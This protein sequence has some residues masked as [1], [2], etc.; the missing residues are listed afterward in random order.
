MI[1]ANIQAGPGHASFASL[2]KDIEEVL[3]EV[4]QRW[5]ERHRIDELLRIIGVPR[6]RTLEET[7]ELES[8]HSSEREE[9]QKLQDPYRGT[10]IRVNAMV[11][12]VRQFLMDGFPETE[13]VFDEFEELLT[14]YGR[15]QAELDLVLK[16]RGLLQ[17][18]S[19]SVGDPAGNVL[20]RSASQPESPVGHQRGHRTPDIETSRKRIALQE[21]LS[22]ELAAVYSEVKRYTTVERLRTKYPQFKLWEVLSDAEQRE[23][24]AGEFKPR[25]YA[26]TLALRKYG[27][28]SLSTL[29]KDRA[30]LRKHLKS[31]A[32]S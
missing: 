2:I 30:K 11:S 13:S 14:R 10:V 21:Q 17:R 27:L 4:K 23:L 24:I 9:Y 28:T 16:I 3:A 1:G 32:A 15:R 7:I 26:G 12:R 22:K 29:K 18:A 25:A 20:I 19:H 6:G 8:P 31:P 5:A